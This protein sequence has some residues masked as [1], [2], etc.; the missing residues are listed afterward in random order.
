MSVLI[1]SI[2][3]GF[4]LDD[5]DAGIQNDINQIPERVDNWNNV[6]KIKMGSAYNEATKRTNISRLQQELVQKYRIEVITNKD[7]GD[8]RKRVESAT[9]EIKDKIAESKYISKIEGLAIGGISKPADVKPNIWIQA[10]WMDRI[11]NDWV[12]ET[13]A[14]KKR[15]E[16]FF[17]YAQKELNKIIEK[18][19]WKLFHDNLGNSIGNVLAYID[20]Y[21][22]DELKKKIKDINEKLEDI[23]TKG[24]TENEQRKAQN[25][26]NALLLTKQYAALNLPQRLNKLNRMLDDIKK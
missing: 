13:L 2:N 17:E 5:F 14:I 12:Q 3:N 25:I 10:Y 22:N 7:G 18:G 24:F 8:I 1:F 19:N 15:D 26:K 20:N 21:L 23:R 16:S 6:Q 11:I 9:G 4:D